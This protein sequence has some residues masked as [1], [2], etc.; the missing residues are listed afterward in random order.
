MVACLLVVPR[1]GHGQDAHAVSVG[2]I[3]VGSADE[4][5][6]I[7]DRLKQGADF[8][9]TAR[10]HSI[11]PSS[12]GGGF[13][14]RV[15]PD[16]LRLE[17]RD[18]LGGL[19]PG[20]ITGVV[21]IPAGYAILKV[22]QPAEG[23]AAQKTPGRAGTLAVSAPVS[24]RLTPVTSGY[25]EFLQSIRRSLPADPT[26]GEDLKATC[27]AR[28]NAPARAAA[29]VRERLEQQGSSMDPLE[30]AYTR[31]TLALLLASQGKSDESLL[32]AEE[33]YRGAMSSRSG[34]LAGHEEQLAGSLEEAIGGAYLHRA[35]MAAHI[36]SPTDETRL[37]PSHPGAPNM[38]PADAE[39]AIEYLTKS[40]RRDPTNNEI[41]Y[42]LN[43]A[44][45]TQGTY[46][47]RVP[48]EF[49]IP[50]ARFASSDDVGRFLDV[51][52][53]AGVNLLGTS[54][55][56]IADDFDNDGLLDLMTS[57]IDDCGPPQFFHNNGDGTF[58]NR[59]K[60][61][62]LSD[63]TGGLNIIQA[64][65]NND[66]CVDFLILRGAWE[67]P[68]RRSLM[69]NNCDGT[70]T[71]VTAQSGLTEPIRS[72]QAAVW[73]DIN[74]DGLLDLFIANESSPSQLFLNKGDG[75]FVDIAHKAGVDK[76]AYSKGVVSADYDNDGYADFFVSNF[77]GPNFLYHNNGDLTFTEVAAKAGVQA[78]WMS[79]PAFFFD[80]DND[81]LPDLFVASYYFSVEEVARG[82][83]GLPR[84]GETLKLYKNKGDGTFQDVT[85]TTGLDRVFMP[86]GSNFGD[87]D[88]DGFLDIYLGNGD[89]SFLSMVPNVLLHNQAGKRFTDISASSGTGALAKG[90][91]VAFADFGNNGNDD[92]LIVMGGPTVGDHYQTRLFRNPGNHGNDWITLHLVGVKSNR[93]AIG[94]RIIVSVENAGGTRRSIYRTVGSGGSFGASPLQQHIG[95]G[96]SAK[97]ASIEVLWPAS[98]TRQK[99]VNVQP[100]QFLEIKEF[101]DT[102]TKLKRPSFAVG[103]AAVKPPRPASRLATR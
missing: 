72:S 62:G 50:P 85:E 35:T 5:Q 80:Y 8:A 19:R 68:R 53:A 78:P 54:G 31:Y 73:A 90:H 101:E 59:T 95:L 25:G 64:D 45:M 76:V 79:F 29:A 102:Y 30:L 33:A 38:R 51:A 66:G 15:D 103:G 46:P 32:Q 39:K 28:T 44:Y 48:K 2:I 55:G 42:L 17:L 100:N 3:V 69:R 88:N 18:A 24:V 16:A 63:Q 58:S 65:Y 26:W 92:I 47:A 43:L 6:K 94:A 13:L 93:S 71:D 91:G 40:L 56:A 98:K 61:A 37:F 12:Y 97:I 21:R 86:M 4:A 96:K 52:P 81:G 23:G 49:L 41:Q 75:T 83:M 22:L 82:Y 67:Y 74:N 77:N 11:D 99:F 20:Q 89:P 57:Q 1:D 34:K 87:V 9:R 70:F 36:D 84:K 14:G 7:L 60:Q 27:D 10:E